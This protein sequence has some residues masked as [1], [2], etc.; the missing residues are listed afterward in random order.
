M[1]GIL[2]VYTSF[3]YLSVHVLNMVFDNIVAH[4]LIVVSL[5]FV[6]F[7]LVVFQV[8]YQEITS[9]QHLNDFAIS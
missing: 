4:V 1:L 8:L 7:P 6:M 9:Q 5:I 3:T 2:D